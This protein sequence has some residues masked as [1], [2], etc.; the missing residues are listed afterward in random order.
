MSDDTESIPLANDQKTSLQIECVLRLA[1]LSLDADY[2]HPEDW[3]EGIG[4]QIRDLAIKIT[5]ATNS[6]LE[7]E[8]DFRELLMRRNEKRNGNGKTDA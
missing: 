8:I 3:K 7:Q 4:G 1:A 6:L 5:E 2:D